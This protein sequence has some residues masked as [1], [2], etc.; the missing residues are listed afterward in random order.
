MHKH[1]NIDTN[2]RNRFQRC[3]LIR[4]YGNAGIT[5]VT[6]ITSE[7]IVKYSIQHKQRV[8]LFLT[9]CFRSISVWFL[10]WY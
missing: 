1:S 4:V 8:S 9:R 5:G 3:R 6:G 7:Y 10:Y 2:M